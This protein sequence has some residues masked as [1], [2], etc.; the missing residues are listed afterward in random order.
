[1]KRCWIP[2][3]ASICDVYPQ[4]KTQNKR[5]VKA[6]LPSL[7]LYRALHGHAPRPS[8]RCAAFTCKIGSP[9]GS[10]L[11]WSC[12]SGCPQ[13][14]ETTWAGWHRK[15][16]RLSQTQWYVMG[17]RRR[18]Q[19][20]HWSNAAPGSG[21]ADRNSLWLP[22]LLYSGTLKATQRAHTSERSFFRLKVSPQLI[23]LSV[24]SPK[25][26]QRWKIISWTFVGLQLIIPQSNEK[27]R[28]TG[29]LLISLNFFFDLLH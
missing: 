16:R 21:P 29:T 7:R 28:P 20:S 5:K 3:Q 11:W 8:P 18:P 6:S 17:R 23:F 13:S 22:G 26:G 14:S 15:L 27:H 4:F 24:L 9:A 10:Y 19:C 12:S 1:M 2:H 25:N